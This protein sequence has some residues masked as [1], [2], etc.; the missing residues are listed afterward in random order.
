MPLERGIHFVTFVHG[1]TSWTKGYLGYSVPK[2][3][4]KLYFLYK[5]I[6]TISLQN[7]NSL[8]RAENWYI[9]RKNSEKTRSP[10][11]L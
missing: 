4:I 7:G 5:F 9:L 3:V 6:V 10:T 1:T 8:N 11:N 2:V